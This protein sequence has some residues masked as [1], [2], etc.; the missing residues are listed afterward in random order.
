MIPEQFLSCGDQIAQIA[1]ARTVN[2][3]AGIGSAETRVHQLNLLGTPALDEAQL[4]H[5]ST[6][7]SPRSD[8]DNP[9]GPLPYID[10]VVPT[11]ESAAVPPDP[12][13]PARDEETVTLRVRRLE[14]Q[15]GA[16]LA[17]GLSGGSPPSYCG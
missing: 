16:L 14:V 8:P 15:V 11:E 6:P 13:E 1:R 10:G 5:P 2:A 9:L 7:A 17:V 12:Q 4:R 3:P